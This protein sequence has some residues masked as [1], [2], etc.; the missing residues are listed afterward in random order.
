VDGFLSGSEGGEPDSSQYNGVR[1]GRQGSSV[2][3]STRGT[4]RGQEQQRPNTEGKRQRNGGLKKRI[5]QGEDGQ[6]R[7]PPSGLK[8]VLSM[9][10]GEVGE[11]TLLMGNKELSKRKSESSE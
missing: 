9:Q 2:S 7:G 11:G 4:G 8:K 10:G 3:N 5:T 1:A 6:G